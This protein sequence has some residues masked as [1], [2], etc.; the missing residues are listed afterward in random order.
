MQDNQ[1]EVLDDLDIKL[2]QPPCGFLVPDLRRLYG[3]L[4]H[5]PEENP[6]ND[7]A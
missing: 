7:I 5:L 6:C 1:M 3:H 4:I 2:K